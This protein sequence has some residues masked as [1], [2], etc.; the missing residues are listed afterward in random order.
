MGSEYEEDNVTG[1]EVLPVKATTEEAMDQDGSSQHEDNVKEQNDRMAKLKAE[2]QKDPEV[3][4]LVKELVE[5][6]LRKEVRSNNVNIIQCSG[7]D[8]WT[9]RTPVI[10]NTSN[11]K[12]I[13]DNCKSPSGTTLGVY[14][15]L[16]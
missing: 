7:A 10:C 3:Q 2:F 13:D 9:G 5:E 12:L 14:I 6:N 8:H 15:H 11:Q 1:N 4:L 16:H